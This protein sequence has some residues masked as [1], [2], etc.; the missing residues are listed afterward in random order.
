M[1][2]C[3]CVCTVYMLPW[4]KCL[5]DREKYRKRTWT[6]KKHNQMLFYQTTHLFTLMR[7]HCSQLCNPSRLHLLSISCTDFP[8]YKNHSIQPLV[9]G[10]HA[11]V[12]LFLNWRAPEKSFPF[13]SFPVIQCN[14]VW[15]YKWTDAYFPISVTCLQL[16]SILFLIR[17]DYL[18]Y[19]V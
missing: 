12:I 6:E 2:V 1:Y 13:L 7:S 5:M 11:T 17:N 19:E 3:V 4:V 14:P 16:V 18:L 8:L 9:Q 10:E 15:F